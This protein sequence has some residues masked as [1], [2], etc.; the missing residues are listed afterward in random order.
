MTWLSWARATI[1]SSGGRATATMSSTA[2][3]GADKLDFGG[4]ATA[5]SIT[6]AA[7]AYGLARV[8]RDVGNATVTL[9]RVE[10][11]EIG[12]LD[13]QD[14]IA[15]NDLSQTDVKS[16]AINLAGAANPNA[17]DGQADTVNVN[18]SSGEPIR[19]AS[20]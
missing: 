8:A 12:T 9:S 11:I 1:H 7:G 13:G 5:E 14:R 15:V 20:G 16:V 6:V 18:G 2:D 10:R 17:G 19:S 3:G 4:S